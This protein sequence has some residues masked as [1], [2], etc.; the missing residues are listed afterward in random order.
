MERAPQRG[1]R[2][3][4]VASPHSACAHATPRMYYCKDKTGSW[5][6]QRG[7]WKVHL[8]ES[9]G[10]TYVEPEP[11][12]DA[13]SEVRFVRMCAV[14]RSRPAERPA[15][16]RHRAHPQARRGQGLRARR[17]CPAR[18]TPPRL[19]SRP[20]SLRLQGQT[21]RNLYWIRAGSI[22]ITKFDESTQKPKQIATLGAN[23]FF[24]ELSVLDKA[25][26]SAT[27]VAETK[28]TLTILPLPVLLNLFQASPGLSKR[29]LKK[30]ATGLAEKVRS[31][32]AAVQPTRAL[33]TSN[34]QNSAPPLLCAR[35]V[36]TLL[37]SGRSRA[38]WSTS[39]ACS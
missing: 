7:G 14:S 29:F 15:A 4:P 18:G 22:A 34:A 24:G 17:D 28:L 32:N 10:A 19:L 25:V 26:I 11:E 38:R 8:T 13:K 33:N 30:I 12:L 36:L 35:A 5:R 21:N 39:R 6:K 20:R 23:R 1:L 31:T 2:V 3:R 9:P 16:Q 37:Q 27:V